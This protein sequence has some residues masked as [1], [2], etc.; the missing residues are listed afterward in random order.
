M[1]L[2]HDIERI[3]YLFA[4]AGF[5]GTPVELEEAARKSLRKV[6][7]QLI[8]DSKAVTDLHVVEPDENETKR[9]LKGLFREGQL[10]KDMLKERVRLNTERVRDLNLQWL[11]QMA[12]GKGALRE[13]M[14]LFW[15]GHFACRAQGRNPLFMQQYANTLRRNA[16]GTFGDLLMAVSKEPAMLQF[17]NNQQNR[18]NAPNSTL[19]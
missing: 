14:A 10:D 19:R 12:S 6:V 11:D 13:K 9:Q 1:K 3:R 4:R 2:L 17:L 18:K 15:H 8:N 16:L 7:R 5:G